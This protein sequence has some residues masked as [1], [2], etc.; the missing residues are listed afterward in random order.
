M[1]LNNSKLLIM[2]RKPITRN[3]SSFTISD[4]PK[5]IERV[6][7]TGDSC[8]AHLDSIASGQAG[9]C[10]YGAC[11]TSAKGINNMFNASG[12]NWD[13]FQENFVNADG[14]E[15]VVIVKETPGKPIYYANPMV[16]NFGVGIAFG[17]AIA[18][19][20]SLIFGSDKK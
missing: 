3:K 16:R 11:D 1:T 7:E 19:G 17:V 12:H 18:W 8:T 4:C 15:E 9:K 14:N 10:T 5:T 2:I 6:G 20:L 13:P